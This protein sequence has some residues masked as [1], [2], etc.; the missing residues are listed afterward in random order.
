[1]NTYED[2]LKK[3]VADEPTD[4]WY[5]SPFDNTDYTIKPIDIKD[6]IPLVVKSK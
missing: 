3:N 2:N 5:D 6:K 1:L 4:E